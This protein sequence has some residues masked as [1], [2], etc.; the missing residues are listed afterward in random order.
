MTVRVKDPWTLPELATIVAVPAATAVTTPFWTVATDVLL[1]LQTN[2]L[3]AIEFLYWSRPRA[4]KV[5][6]SPLC[7]VPFVVTEETEIEVNCGGASCTF[8]I[9][10]GDVTVEHMQSCDPSHPAVVAQTCVVAVVKLVPTN[11]PVT[12]PD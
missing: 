5:L 6:T 3:T 8:T 12:R 1:L 9:T 11:T 7:T 10:E 4:V 2:V